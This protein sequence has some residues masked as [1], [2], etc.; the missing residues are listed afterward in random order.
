MRRVAFL[1]L[2]CGL[3]C[4][5]QLDSNSVTIQASRVVTLQPDLATL[6]I[7][8]TSNLS[9]G[10]D[11]VI[12]ALQGTGITSA[13]L[14]GV[15]TITGIPLRN[16]L[17]ETSLA[18]T[19]SLAVP[20][21]ALKNTTAT[22]STLQG[23][24]AQQSRGL[25]LTFAVQ[26]SDVSPQL[27]ASQT[28]AIPDLVADAR[29]QAKKL[30]DTA[31][32]GL[33]PIL[34]LADSPAVISPWFDVASFRSGDFS[35]GAAYFSPVAVYLIPVPYFAPSVSTVSCSLAVKFGLLRN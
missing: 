12:A 25:A 8:V 22:L 23:N 13:N 6:S 14:A 32:L 20:F 35:P 28:C 19:F 29:A 30:S 1:L 16:L 15:N 24:I 33:G 11:A 5:G 26:G 3:S 7:T 34:A 10:L 4:F 18:W 21:A 17:P 2:A 31:G 9:T 27:R